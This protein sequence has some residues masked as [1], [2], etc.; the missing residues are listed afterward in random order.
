MNVFL[1]KKIIGLP[2]AALA[3]SMGGCVGSFD[4]HT[5]TASPLAPRIQQLV[6]SHDRYPRWEDF[7]TASTDTPSAA[8]VA[9]KVEGMARVN[10]S[11]AAQVLAIDWTTNPDPRVF[12]AMVQRQFDPAAMGPIGPQ[13]TPEI[14]ALADSLRQKATPPPPIDRP[15]L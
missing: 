3:A 4:P 1:S 13:T 5:D 14:E 6:D 7:P 2:L 8:Y 15:R 11:L 12:E 9:Q 10:Q